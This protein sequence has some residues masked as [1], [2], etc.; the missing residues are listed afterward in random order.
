[1]CQYEGM[2]RVRSVFR[3]ASAASVVERFGSLPKALGFLRRHHSDSPFR[4][5]AD[6]RRDDLL[7]EPPVRG[8]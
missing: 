8:T 3:R 5:A 6:S 7:R 4:A 1:M 2:C